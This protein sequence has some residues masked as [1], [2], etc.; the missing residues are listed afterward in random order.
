MRAS[1]PAPALYLAALAFLTAAVLAYSHRRVGDDAR[2]VAAALAVISVCGA[3]SSLLRR[4]L[5]AG[6]CALVALLGVWAATGGVDF[7][8]RDRAR[9]LVDG[10][11]AVALLSLVLGPPRDDQ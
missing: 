5:V 2:L 9:L 1:R 8:L 11:L 4:R 10:A 7:W 3:V 6:L